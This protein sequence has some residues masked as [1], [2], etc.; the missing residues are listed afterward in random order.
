MGKRAIETQDPAPWGLTTLTNPGPDE[1]SAYVYDSEGGAGTYAYVIDSGINDA[2][3]DFSGRASRVWT[4]FP[5]ESDDDGRGHGTHVAATIGGTK[6]GV[7]KQASL[8]SVKVFSGTSP[9]SVAIVIDGLNWAVNDIV[10]KG[11]QNSAV[12]NMSLS[13]GFSAALNDAVTA[14]NDA[15]VVV[16][17]IA[18]NDGGS[19]YYYSPASAKGAFTV[20]AINS[21]WHIST[22]SN[23]GPEL[24][25]FAP[26]TAIESAWIGGPDAINTISGTSMAAPHVAGLVLHAFSREG[27]TGTEAMRSFLKTNGTPDKVQGYMWN[28]DNLVL[29]NGLSA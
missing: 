29:N 6:Y 19:A 13:G 16:V 8:L 26:G 3:N 14:A 4:A 11:R 17:V 25:I 27:I 24:I 18:G 20:G 22:F 5:D 9:S 23:H 1:G 7:A 28:T 10:S 15:G 2:H 12:V 21:T